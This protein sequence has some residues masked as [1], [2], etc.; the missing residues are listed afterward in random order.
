MKRGI[1]RGFA[2]ALERLEQRDV[3]AIIS[4]PD[5]NGVIIIEGTNAADHVSVSYDSTGTQVVINDIYSTLSTSKASVKKIVFTGHGGDDYF[6]NFTAI[7]SVADGGSG[8]DTLWGGSGTDYLHGGGDD[9]LLL[10]GAG[11]DHLYGEGGKDTLFGMAG[12]D[13]LD[14]GNDGLVDYLYGGDGIDIYNVH[15]FQDKVQDFGPLD[16]LDIA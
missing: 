8:K 13:Y 12:S 10:G 15:F 11:A 3:P 7:P 5:A 1:Q 4:W 9:D 14:G 2:P 6:G 16:V